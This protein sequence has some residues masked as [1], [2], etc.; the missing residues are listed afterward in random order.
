MANQHLF[1]PYPGGRTP[2][3]CVKCGLPPET[4]V[5]I[6]LLDRVVLRDEAPT[7]LARSE[8]LMQVAELYAQRSSCLRGNIGAVIAKESRIISCGYSG[9]PAGM[10]QCDEVGCD[11]PE[12]NCQPE[13][14]HQEGYPHA[15]DCATQLGCQRTIH[16]EGN[17]IVWA[18]RTGV[19]TLDCEMYSTHSPCAVCARLIIAAGISKFYYR[20]DYRLGRLDLLDKAH[21][22]C[23]QL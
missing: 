1:A 3:S 4:D 13:G 2:R 6:Q 23:E 5:H 14:G 20:I 17:A 15:T 7:R 9:A 22:P 16:A 21:I 8:L 12:C 11:V 18:A 19:P 10:Q